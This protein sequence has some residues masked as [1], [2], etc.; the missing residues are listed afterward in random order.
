VRDHKRRQRPAVDLRLGEAASCE[1]TAHPERLERIIGHVVQNALDATNE[2]GSVSVTLERASSARVRV[3]VEDNGCGMSPDFVRDR[4]SRPFQTTKA[5]GMG[6]G[7]FETRQYLEEI[8][9]TLRYDSAVGVGTR[10]TIELPT[11]RRDL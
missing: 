9:G 10:V 4:L 2:D 5:S 8:G 3:V 7:V 1:V 6:I 11:S